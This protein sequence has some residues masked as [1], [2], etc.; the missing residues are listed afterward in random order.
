MYDAKDFINSYEVLIDAF[1]ANKVHLYYV[2]IPTF[3]CGQIFSFV[4]KD[5]NSHPYANLDQTKIK[6]FLSANP[7]KYYT[8]KTHRHAFSVPKFFTKHL[9][10]SKQKAL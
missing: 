6:S 5:D 9:E 4:R 8:D 2:N 7:T 3:H 1:G 10:K